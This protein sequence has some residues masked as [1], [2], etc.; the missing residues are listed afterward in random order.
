MRGRSFAFRTVAAA[1]AA[2][3]LA[4]GSMG[5]AKAD[6]LKIRMAWVVAPASLVPIMFKP[7]GVATHLGKSYVVEDTRIGASSQQITALASNQ[8]DIAALNYASLSLAVLNGH[9]DDIRIL[10]DEIQDGHPGYYSVQ[11]WVRKDSGIQKIEDLRGKT[12]ATNGFG[13]GTHMALT[14]VM[15]NHGMKAPQDYH[16]VEVQFPHMAAV[17]ADKKVDVAIAPSTFTHNEKFLSMARPLFTMSDAFGVSTLS[18]WTARKE[19]IDKHRAVLVDLIEDYIRAIRW[20]TDPKNQKEASDIVSK[21]TK[22]P[23]KTFYGWL[24]TKEDFYRDPNAVP[25][26]AALQRNIEAAAKLGVIPKPIVAKNYEM[27]SIAREA[28]ARVK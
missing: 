4:A 28:A 6:P 10:A 5:P 23:A 1:L 20:Y 25:D 21:F 24:F 18:F 2:A 7:P 17:L 26:L 15:Q 3:G 8:I 19:F 9:L 22:I 16:V 13:T 14:I 12:L 27:L 11:Y